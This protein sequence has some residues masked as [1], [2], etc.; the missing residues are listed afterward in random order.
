MKFKALVLEYANY[1]EKKKVP[2]A[3]ISKFR[4]SVNSFLPWYYEAS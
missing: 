3:T 4:D 2:I 1:F